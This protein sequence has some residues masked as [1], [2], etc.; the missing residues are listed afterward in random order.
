M[1][2]HVHELN[3]LRMKLIERS[4]RF[5]FIFIFFIF[6]WLCLSG[7]MEDY[8]L[9]QRTERRTVRPERAAGAVISKL[10]YYRELV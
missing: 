3:C 4:G 1:E 5:Y 8:V 2:D 9:G 6:L 7:R 10:G